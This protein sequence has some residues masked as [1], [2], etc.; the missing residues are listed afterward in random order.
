MKAIPDKIE[1]PFVSFLQQKIP[2]ALFTIS[3]LYY[4]FLLFF[5]KLFT[6]FIPFIKT[7]SVFTD[8]FVDAVGNTIS[9]WFVGW[10]R[11]RDQI[12]NEGNI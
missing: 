5:L 11:M 12:I 7:D 10:H 1:E 4:L 9:E 8:Y 2:I 3:R 6:I